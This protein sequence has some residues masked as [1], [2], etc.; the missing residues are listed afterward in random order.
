[1]RTQSQLH[2]L[3]LT[4]A[5]DQPNPSDAIDWNPP[6]ASMVAAAR[7]ELEP[8]VGILFDTD[9]DRYGPIG[10]DEGVG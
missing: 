10:F 6:P 5:S 8:R 2:G 7:R 3:P 1:M 9:P 4:Y